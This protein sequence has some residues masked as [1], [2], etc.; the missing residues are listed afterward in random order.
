M[1]DAYFLFYVI[2]RNSA[3]REVVPHAGSGGKYCIHK[4][5][6]YFDYSDFTD[7]VKEDYIQIRNIKTNISWINNLLS[8]YVQATNNETS[9]IWIMI[10]CSV[11]VRCS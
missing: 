8:S 10:F 7:V 9:R 3:K 4:T 11:M 2:D 1:S 5:V 6:C